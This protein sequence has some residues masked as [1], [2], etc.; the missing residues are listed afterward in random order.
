VKDDRVYLKHILRCVS[1]IEEYAVGGR[2]SGIAPDGP[3]PVEEGPMVNA[4]R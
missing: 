3:V 2:D 1:R 4:G